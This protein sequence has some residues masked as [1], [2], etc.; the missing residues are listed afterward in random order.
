MENLTK[1]QSEILRFIKENKTVNNQE[2]KEFL[3]ANFGELSRITIIRD[4]AELLNEGFIKKHGRGRAVVYSEFVPNKLLSYFD[5]NEYFQKSPDERLVSFSR[6]NFEV[7]EHFNGIFSKDELGA[8]YELNNQYQE[9][10]KN[11]SPVVLKKEYERLIIELS[12]KSSKIEGNTYSLIDTEILIKE[13]LEATG[14]RKEEAIMILNHKKALD[15]IFSQPVQFQRINI[16]SVENIHNFLTEGLG[17]GGG[18]RQRPVG[19]TG[20]IF[21]PLDNQHQIIEAMEKTIE[22]INHLADPFSKALAAVL[23]LSYIQAFEDG[24]KRTARIL[25]DAILL[26]HGVCP[27]SYRSI[28]ESDYKKAILLFYEQNSAR[29]FK[30]LFIDQ[31]KFAVSNYFL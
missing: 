10:I 14:H 21:K 30:E 17:I 20:T 1:R 16:R 26:A 2:I 6:F 28:D 27:L 29:F 13:E 7:F 3:K 11:I 12:W 4:L 19:I 22:T 25:S 24:N 31:F 5:P 8:L 18:L 23:L 9:R 15:F